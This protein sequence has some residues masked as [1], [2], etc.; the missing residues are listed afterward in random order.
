VGWRW[1][2]DVGQFTPAKYLY[3]NCHA[4]HQPS[5]SPLGRASAV[6]ARDA[7]DSGLRLFDFD[8]VFSK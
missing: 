7:L 3:G 6:P 4:Q 8:M 1:T 5:A 2:I